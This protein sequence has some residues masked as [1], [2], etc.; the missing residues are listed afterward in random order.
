MA[1]DTYGV[2]DNERHKRQAGVVPPEP[3]SKF[4]RLRLRG[5]QVVIALCRIPTALAA[6]ALCNR[7]GRVPQRRL[8][9]LGFVRRLGR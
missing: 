6:S 7:S 3:Q 5:V 2:P 9:S 8:Q 1:F 4:E